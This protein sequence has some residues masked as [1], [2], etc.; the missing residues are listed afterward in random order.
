MRIKKPLAYVG[1]FV[2]L[3]LILAISGV[4][5]GFLAKRAHTQALAKSLKDPDSLIIEEHKTY[6]PEKK[7]IEMETYN[8]AEVLCSEVT[9]NAKNSFGGYAGSSTSRAAILY[10]RFLGVPYKVTAT[11]ETMAMDIYQ[12]LN[13]SSYLSL[14]RSCNE[15]I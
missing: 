6:A 15:H 7:H 8:G 14:A 1:G 13:I 12:S 9:Y 5:N 4:A 11:T 3:S 10:W 2:F